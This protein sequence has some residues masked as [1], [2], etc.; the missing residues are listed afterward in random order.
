MSG[1]G[2]FFCFLFTGRGVFASLGHGEVAVD[3]L[4]DARAEGD[5]DLFLK[6][7]GIVQVAGQQHHAKVALRSDHGKRQNLRAF[8]PAYILQHLRQMRQGLQ[9]LF[10]SEQGPS[11]ALDG[12]KKMKNMPPF[13]RTQ[14]RN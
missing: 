14:G 12:I 10:G 2:E 1:G 9:A 11:R 6:G 4:Q 13:L 3:W 7:I 8:M 5:R